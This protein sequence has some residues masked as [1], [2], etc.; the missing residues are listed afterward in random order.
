MTNHIQME[1]VDLLQ[2]K[3]RCKKKDNQHKGPSKQNHSPRR[4]ENSRKNYEGSTH[5]NLVYP[6]DF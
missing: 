1:E 2:Y 5:D 3:P 6:E 4:N